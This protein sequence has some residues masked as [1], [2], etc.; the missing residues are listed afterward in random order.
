MLQHL[1]PKQYNSKN[2]HKTSQTVKAGS[3]HLFAR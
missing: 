1:P 3:F 2:K